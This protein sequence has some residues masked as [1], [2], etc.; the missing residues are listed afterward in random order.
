MTKDQM[1]HNL[2]NLI[3]RNTK[4][5]PVIL[6]FS[7]GEGERAPDFPTFPSVNHVSPGEISIKEYPF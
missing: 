2:E 5:L 1:F 4:V 6:F 3:F 7:G